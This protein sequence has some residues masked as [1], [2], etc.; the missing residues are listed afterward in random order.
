VPIFGAQ[1]VAVSTCITI[2]GWF[3]P[4]VFHQ[5]KKVDWQTPQVRREL[6]SASA[7]GSA[8][9][10][11]PVGLHDFHQLRLDVFAGSLKSGAQRPFHGLV[12]EERG[13]GPLVGRG[14]DVGERLRRRQGQRHDSDPSL[15]VA[16]GVQDGRL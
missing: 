7:H 6:Q 11:L 14:I 15:A 1:S 8:C 16:G 12:A 13:Y 10:F 5:A 9:Q 2:A 3:S 4:D